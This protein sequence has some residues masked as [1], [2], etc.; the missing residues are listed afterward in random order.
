MTRLPMKMLKTLLAAML[1]L[2]PASVPTAM[3]VA[4]VLGATAA[5]TAGCGGGGGDEDGGDE[6]GGGGNDQENENDG[7]D[8]D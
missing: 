8:D 4:G 3:A 1:A 2:T 7:G 6:D 5:V